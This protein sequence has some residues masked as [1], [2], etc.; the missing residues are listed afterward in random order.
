MT[1]GLKKE[2]MF[3]APIYARYIRIVVLE[4]NDWICM[5]AALIVKSCSTCFSNAVSL[6]GSTASSACECW[7]GAYKYS[8]AFGNRA[9]VLVPGRGAQFSTL[10]NR[11]QRL[12]AA[13]AIFNS[14]AG[15]PGS[16]GAVTFDRVFSQYLDSGTHT[17]NVATN[18][19]FTIVSVVKFSVPGEA[20]MGERK[21]ILARVPKTTM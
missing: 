20:A 18:G 7:A 1:N 15:P 8:S 5:R 9:I 14:T 2:H 10:A 6:Q 21:L 16:K 4:W 19:G 12:F 13:T 17:F 3:P 11:N